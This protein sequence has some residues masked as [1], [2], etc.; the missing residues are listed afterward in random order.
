MFDTEKS[1]QQSKIL[2]S[3]SIEFHELSGNSINDVVQLQQ[4]VV[5]NLEDKNYYNPQSRESLLRLLGD[6]GKTVGAFSE[7]KLVAVASLLFPGTGKENLGIDLGM[8]KDQLEQVVH[9]DIVLVDSAYRGLGLQIQMFTDLLEEIKNTYR[10]ACATVYP[11]NIASL[12]SM[13]KLGLSVVDLKKKYGGLL[14]YIL[15]ADIRKVKN[16]TY[17]E[18]VNLELSDYNKQTEL[19]SIGHHG[20][21]IISNFNTYNIQYGI[22]TIE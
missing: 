18:I 21:N 6:E 13:M 10:F 19:L 15:C 4:R 22:Q 8:S 12:K 3:A 17:N 7:G 16:I 11:K 1:P 5:D 14:R 2:K 20:F 9:L